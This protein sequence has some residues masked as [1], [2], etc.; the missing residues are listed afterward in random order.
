MEILI[1]LAALATIFG[2]ILSR[3]KYLKSKP[4]IVRFITSINGSKVVL[5]V[6]NVSN[7]T[8]TVDSVFIRKIYF[9]FF[10][11]SPIKVDLR[12]ENDRD[13][14]IPPTN[15]EKDNI[16]F[17]PPEDVYFSKYK[18]YIKTS[19]QNCSKIYDPDTVDG[20]SKSLVDQDKAA[21]KLKRNWLRRKLNL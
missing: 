11:S 15:E 1:S 18:I 9:W 5:A 20:I 19:G 13:I 21:K 8:I 4:R 17:R 16:I 10:K 7:T 14:I 2:F 6:I 12:R 3:H